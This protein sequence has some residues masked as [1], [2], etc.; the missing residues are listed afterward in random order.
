VI[1]LSSAR[2]KREMRERLQNAF[3]QVEFKFCMGRMKEA[4][5]Y[6]ED[7]TVLITY[8]EDL[9]PE[10]IEKAKK[11]KWIMV[12][13]AGLDKMPFK[14][15]EQKGILVTNARG[16]HAIPM[17]EYTIAMML[18]VNR[19]TK[20]LIE[21]EQKQIWDRTVK[22]EE[23][24]DL[25]LG[26]IGTGA[27]GQEIARLA[28]AFSMKTLGVNTS[29]KEKDYFD[30]VFKTEDM[31]AVF[32]KSDFIVNVVPSTKETYQFINSSHFKQMKKS[33]VFINI[34]R[35]DTVNE[36]DLLH[37]LKTDELSHAV[38]D[39][40]HREPLAP[41]HPFWK[42]ENVTVTP[43]LSGISPK[44]QQRAFD[45]FIENF[46]VFLNG[47]GTYKNMIDPKRGY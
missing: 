3:P 14:E 43:H 35:G 37:A 21:H 11:L 4:E 18:Q 9:L 39:V 8:G 32:A 15:I 6:L 29:G 23:I 46:H 42:M 7:A 2:V 30:E 33:S 36:D 24:T 47:T 31:M 16:I 44:Y 10:H 38:L 5:K 27:I 13:S 28:K 25:T 22:M 17:A 1:V 34:G 20:I 19:Q 45:I 26:V 40:F 12:I 41:E